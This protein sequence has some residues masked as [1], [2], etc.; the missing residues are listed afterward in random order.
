MG[1]LLSEIVANIKKSPGS[2]MEQNLR[3]SSGSAHCVQFL[4][5]THNIPEEVLIHI[6]SYVDAQTLV[7]LRLCCKLWKELIDKEV[8]KMKAYRERY[9]SL[10]SVNPKLKLPWYVYYIIC[11]RDP[12]EKNLIRNHCGQEQL[13]HWNIKSSGGDRWVIEDPPQ[14][15]DTLPESEEIEN[16]SSCFATSFYSCSKEQLINLNEHG[17][18][19]K[20]MDEVQPDIEVS[21][22][23]AG[24]F[25]CGCIYEMQ[26]ELQNENQ[27]EVVNFSCR[28][29]I[30]QWQGREWNKVSHVFRNY[31][32][33]VRFIRFYHGGVDTQFWAGHYGSKMTGACVKLKIPKSLPVNAQQ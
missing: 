14:G 26:A 5:I 19:D 17:F 3:I 10:R 22:W 13:G 1:Q 29:S 20:I 32:K 18:N 2:K 6:L 9:S 23:Y 15:A 27:E 11:I 30:E 16:L 31:D 25:D 8:W 4:P 33:G 7:N 21:E 28:E 12:F 24:R